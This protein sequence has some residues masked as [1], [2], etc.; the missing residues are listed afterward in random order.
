MTTSVIVLVNGEN[1]EATVKTTDENGIVRSE[2]TA[3]G[4]GYIQAYVTSGWK[5]EITEK[6]LGEVQYAGNLKADD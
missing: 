1:Y 2:Q 5:M 6:Y 4:G 3:K